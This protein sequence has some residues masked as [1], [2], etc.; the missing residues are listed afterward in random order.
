MLEL[1]IKATSFEDI[2][3]ISDLAAAEAYEIVVTDG[4]RVVNAK[5][6]M[7]IFSLDMDRPLRLQLDCSETDSESFRQKAAGYIVY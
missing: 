4:E 5:S 1:H 3:A 7:S 2:R 6:L